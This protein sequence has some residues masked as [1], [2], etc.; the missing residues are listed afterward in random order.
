MKDKPSSLLEEDTEEMRKWRDMN[1]E[2]FEQNAVRNWRKEWRWKFWTST[3]LRT[4]KGSAGTE[5]CSQMQEIQNKKV[6]RRLLGK[7][8]RLVQRIQPAASAKHA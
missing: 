4:A 8:L 3:R 5:A 7:N 2:E 1:Q 6:E